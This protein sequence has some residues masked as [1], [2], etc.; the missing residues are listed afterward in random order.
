MNTKQPFKIWS[1]FVF[2][3]KQPDLIKNIGASGQARIVHYGSAIGYFFLIITV[4]HNGKNKIVANI[5]LHISKNKITSAIF[6]R[7]NGF[8]YEIIVKPVIRIDKS[9]ITPCCFHDAFILTIGMAT[10]RL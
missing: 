5:I 10:I 4:T 9:N 1:N 8:L 3:V 7:F 2:W 6:K